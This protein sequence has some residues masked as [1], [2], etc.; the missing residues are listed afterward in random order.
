MAMFTRRHYAALADVVGRKL[1]QA[2]DEKETNAIFSVDQAL[3]GLFE[4]DN[5]RFKI[6]RWNAAVAAAADANHREAV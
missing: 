1:N 6:S 4:R 2:V 5:P 3:V